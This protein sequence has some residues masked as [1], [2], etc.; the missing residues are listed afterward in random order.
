MKNSIGDS[1]AIL[2]KKLSAGGLAI[3]LAVSTFMG[4]TSALA[5]TA[6]NPTI[7]FDGNTLATSVPKDELVERAN[8]NALT[9]SNGPLAKVATTTRAGYTFGG[10][11]FEKGGAAVTQLSTVRTSDTFRLI[12]AVWNT[13]IRYNANGADSGALTNFKTQDVYRFGQDLALP[14]AGTLVKQGYSFGGWMSQPY[15]ATRLTNYSAGRDDVGNLTMY[16]AWIKNVAFDAN[17]AT[18]TTPA[19]LVYTFGGPK[20]KLPSFTETLLRKPGY[21]FA[22]WSLL[23]NGQTAVNSLGYV[24]SQAQA[25]LYA[26]WK[27]QG[28]A[29]N[30]SISFKPGKSALSAGQREALYEL[31]TSIGRGTDVKLTVAAVRASGTTKALGK[32]R[33]AAVVRYL[34]SLGIDAAI[35]RSNTVRN[36]GTV[37]SPANNR[38]TVQATWTNPAN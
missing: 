34:R 20:L 36:F 7:S 18:G 5:S 3:V 30:A 9:V 4:S 23:P 27:A 37:T 14:S 21:N 15:S 22:G 17:G 6:S 12:Y 1:R 24:P 2:R 33:N 32:A 35:S 31:A 8:E 11:S 19:S 10:W 25:T 38:V 29:A 26:I 13:T 16:A 28:T